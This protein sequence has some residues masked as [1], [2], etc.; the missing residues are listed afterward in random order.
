VRARE[1]ALE[2]LRLPP[3]TQCET[4]NESLVTDAAIGGR[5]VA[6]AR[7]ALAQRDLAEGRFIRPLQEEIPA[8]FSYWIVCSSENAST[9][10]IARFRDWLLREAAAG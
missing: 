4:S 3:K 2:R 1:Q 10:K 8:P 6:L 9:T 7:S 5:V